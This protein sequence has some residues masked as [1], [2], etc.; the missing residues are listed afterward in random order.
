[1]E[2][3]ICHKTAKCAWSW[4]P[5]SLEKAIIQ[6]SQGYMEHS[7][8]FSLH[9]THAEIFATETAQVGWPMFTYL[10]FPFPYPV[11]HLGW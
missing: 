1:M 10:L 8:E 2:V 9:W 3:G 7:F 5:G 11:F 4:F 6:T